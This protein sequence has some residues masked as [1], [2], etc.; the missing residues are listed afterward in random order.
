M[1]EVL[2]FDRLG[3]GHPRVEVTHRL[4][5]LEGDVLLRD[6]DV[7]P[8]G[9]PE[10]RLVVYPSVAGS[11]GLRTDYNPFQNAS[12]IRPGDRIALVM[13]REFFNSQ[14]VQ[15]NGQFD[16]ELTLKRFSPRNPDPPSKPLRLRVKIV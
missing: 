12:V 6:I 10:G 2:A 15:S 7:G 11:V 4:E 1:V 13:G 16:L 3:P 5:E 14:L 9:A 8:F